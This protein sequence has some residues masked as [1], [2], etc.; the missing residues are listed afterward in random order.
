MSPTVPDPNAIPSPSRADGLLLGSSRSIADR[1]PLGLGSPDRSSTAHSLPGRESKLVSTRGS[2]PWTVT[3]EELSLE[4]E[5]TEKARNRMLQSKLGIVA[6]LFHSL[7]AKHVPTASH[8]L[9]VGLCASAWGITE[10][11]REKELEQVEIAGLL[12]DIGKIGIPD[13]ILQKPE[14]L[15]PDEQSMMGLHPKIGLEILRAAGAN[16]GLLEIIRQVGIWYNQFPS[17]Q[18]KGTFDILAAQMIS[19]ADAYDAMTTDQAY[20]SALRQ[21]EALAELFKNSGTQFNPKLVR[22]FANSLTQR[23]PQVDSIFQQR[24]LGGF[25]ALEGLLPSQFSV[26][27]MLNL[28]AAQQSL[29]SVFRN[30]LLDTM[31][32]GVIFV[33]LDRQILEWNCTAERLAALTRPLL[34]RPITPALTPPSTASMNDRRFSESSWAVTRSR[35]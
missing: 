25:R 33:D 13:R 11:L 30:Q 23:S 21:E 1:V 20:R 27:S 12:H 10:R 9:R 14:R 32:D 29:T 5:E 34:S 35:R 7:H 19:I 28:N 16:D 8:C 22:S 15:N 4:G 26:V 24:W 3:A 2:V 6:S 31:Q 18:G 17:G